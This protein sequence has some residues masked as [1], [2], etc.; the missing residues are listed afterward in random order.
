MERFACN[1][2]ISISISNRRNRLD[3]RRTL[4]QA[5]GSPQPILL[6]STHGGMFTWL[7]AEAGLGLLDVTLKTMLEI[8]RPGEASE[9]LE[10][11]SDLDLRSPQSRDFILR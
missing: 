6:R 1:N 7:G 4:I 2:Q 11:L 3:S 5:E 10:V 9:L 8:Y